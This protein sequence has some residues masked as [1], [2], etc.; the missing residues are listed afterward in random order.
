[1]WSFYAST[2]N[3]SFR[4]TSPTHQRE[5][6]F[7]FR[8]IVRTIYRSPAYEF[9]WIMFMT[10]CERES[11]AF[12]YLRRC[13]VRLRSR[14]HSKWHVGEAHTHSHLAYS[15]NNNNNKLCQRRGETHSTSHGDGYTLA[16]EEKKNQR[17]EEKISRNNKA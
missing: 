17:K 6:V 3:G 5:K 12:I 15:H 4:S 8:F 7:P 10:L 13:F 2:H 9:V 16:T 11:S 14:S 1:M